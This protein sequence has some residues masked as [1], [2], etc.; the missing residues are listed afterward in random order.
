MRALSLAIATAALTGCAAFQQP[1][2]FPLTAYPGATA[3]E[4]LLAKVNIE[5]NRARPCDQ[6]TR[7]QRAIPTREEVE[8][9]NFLDSKGYTMAKAYALQDA[10]IDESRMRAAEFRNMGRPHMVLVVDN[11]WV[12][13]NFYDNPRHVSEYSRLRPVQESV[14]PTLM[15]NARLSPT[16]IAARRDGSAAVGGG[17]PVIRQAD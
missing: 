5:T 7:C 14:P 4:K 12:L 2:D 6:L 8:T 15:A 10:G 13:D 16:Y 11:R 9:A 3:E 17:R 1:A